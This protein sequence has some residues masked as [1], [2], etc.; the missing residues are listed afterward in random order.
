MITIILQ[1]LVLHESVS[2]LNHFIFYGRYYKDISA[3]PI[4]DNKESL[5]HVAD[6][7]SAVLFYDCEL[8]FIYTTW[9]SRTSIRTPLPQQGH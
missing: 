9:S 3:A 2:V 7:I 5:I 6:S 4:Q 1:V 8:M